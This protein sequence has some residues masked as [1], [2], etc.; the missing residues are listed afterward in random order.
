MKS[1]LIDGISNQV[2]QINIA[3]RAGIAA[4]IG[5][6]TLADDFIAESE[7]VV[8]DENCFIRG[9]AGRFQIDT[10]APIAGKAI[11]VGVI[12]SDLVDSK[13]TVMDISSRVKFL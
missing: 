1:F 10:L 3:D 11:I 13:L 7:I 2:T 8:F 5:F 6:S 12:G 9:S 4:E